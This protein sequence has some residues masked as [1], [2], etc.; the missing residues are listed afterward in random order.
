[1]HDLR[2]LHVRGDRMK[3]TQERLALRVKRLTY[4]LIIIGIISIATTRTQNFITTRRSAPRKPS[5]GAPH[6]ATAKTQ[7]EH[8][9]TAAHATHRQE[10]SHPHEQACDR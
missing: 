8:I 9:A 5:S 3:R 10:G 1:M 7:D 2:L 6:D 4:A